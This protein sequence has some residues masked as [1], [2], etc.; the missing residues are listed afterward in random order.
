MAAHFS[1]IPANRSVG[2]G[3]IVG[4]DAPRCAE[5]RSELRWPRQRRTTSEIS[6]EVSGTREH[7]ELGSTSEDD[8][9][10]AGYGDVLSSY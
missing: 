10:L 1:T 9:E 8:G 6:L 2:V 3:K 5:S 7:G 4:G